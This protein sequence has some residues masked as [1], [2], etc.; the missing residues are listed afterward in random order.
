[1]KLTL[2][3]VIVAFCTL[4]GTACFVATVVFL[5]FQLH[6]AQPDASGVINE[7]TTAEFSVSNN[8]TWEKT[9]LPHDWRMQNLNVSQI[10]YRFSFE[11]FPSNTDLYALY[12]PVISQNAVAYLNGTEVGNGGSIKEPVTRNWPGPL[13]FP[14]ASEFLIDG[15][16]QLKIQVFSEPVGKGLLPVF[17]FGKWTD[18]VSSYNYRKVLKKN[19][20][21]Y[22]YGDIGCCCFFPFL[23]RLES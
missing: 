1:M 17:Y 15:T 19:G 23:Y 9:S 3:R 20:F 8:A 21:S 7:F 22:V 6:R 16:N 4:L 5:I 14:V 10:R 18:L 12:L 13:I 2:P 11:F